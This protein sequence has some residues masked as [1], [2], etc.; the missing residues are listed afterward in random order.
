MQDLLSKTKKAFVD[1]REKYTIVIDIDNKK[2]QW[3]KSGKVKV[4]MADIQLEKSEAD[5]QEVQKSF[6]DFLIRENRNIKSTNDDLQRRQDNLVR[7]LRQSQKTL[8]IFEKEK[9]DLE[10]NLIS[11]FLPIL[12]AKKDEIER[13]RNLKRSSIDD[14]NVDYDDEDTDIDDEDGVSRNGSKCQRL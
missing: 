2:L 4:K 3:K 6:M 7:D 8:E 5:Y 11:N 10:D 1:D 14:K 9:T 12:N 13:L